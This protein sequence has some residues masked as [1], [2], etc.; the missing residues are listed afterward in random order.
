[1]SDNILDKSEFDYKNKFAH[2]KII[3]LILRPDVVF[4]FQVTHLEFHDENWKKVLDKA[5]KEKSV[6]GFMYRDEETEDLPV[7]G[8]VATSALIDEINKTASGSYIVKFVPINRF[9]TKE[10]AVITPLL[11]RF[12]KLLNRMGKIARSKNLETMN[13]EQLREDIQFYSFSVFRDHPKLTKHEELHA[14]WMYKLSLRLAWL[15][16]LLESSLN[17]NVE[18]IAATRFDAQNN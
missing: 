18:R 6:I 10:Y 5:H 14:L 17:D 11:K 13:L 1:M 8:R 16:E 7:I 4:P 15:I 2:P 12:L 9:F 3:P